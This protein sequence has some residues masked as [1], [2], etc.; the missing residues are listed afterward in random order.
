MRGL[1]AA[2]LASILS[3]GLC[4][5]APQASAG[6]WLDVP[7]VKQTEDG[8]GSA[9]ISML[10]QYWNAHGATVSPTLSDVD[11]IQ[12]KLYSKKAKGIF[13]QDIEWY[14]KASGFRAYSF[15]GDWDD[16]RHHLTQ[17]RPL[18]VSIEPRPQ[19]P[20]HYVIVTGMDWRHDAVFVND[21]ARGKLLRIE[22]QEFQNEWFAA[23]NWTLLAVPS[24]AS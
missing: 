20:L 19:A 7:F 9:S 8:C 11:A 5:A 12:K 2:L 15:R 17:G 16:L 4:R 24:P 13:A 23:R 6:V 14:F 18:M 21:P 10:L 3:L 1:A 22:R